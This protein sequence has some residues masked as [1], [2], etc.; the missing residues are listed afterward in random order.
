MENEKHTALPC[1]FHF[2]FSISIK[3]FEN[4][5]A[6]RQAQAPSFVEGMQGQ[7][8]EETGDVRSQGNKTFLV[9]ST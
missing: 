5:S 6:V 1:I 9:L 4:R 8:V 2:L 3:A 7:R